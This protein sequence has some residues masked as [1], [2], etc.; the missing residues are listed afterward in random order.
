L[1]FLVKTSI[2]RVELVVIGFARTV[3]WH[4]FKYIHHE[5]SPREIADLRFRI[6]LVNLWYVYA[7]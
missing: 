4:S 7:V 2:A 1:S 6:G 3:D 5:L